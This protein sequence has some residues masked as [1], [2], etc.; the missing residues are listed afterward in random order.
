ML[1]VHWQSG[2]G[3]PRASLWQLLCVGLASGRVGKGQDTDGVPATLRKAPGPLSPPEL[4]LQP[5]ALSSRALVPQSYVYR[6][7]PCHSGPLFSQEG[8]SVQKQSGLVMAVSFGPFSLKWVI[9]FSGDLRWLT[10]ISTSPA[11]PRKKGHL[12]ASPHTPHLLVPGVQNEPST[13]T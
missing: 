13:C 8:P 10:V 5:W 7:P 9:Y 11:L 2:P 12:R 1:W 3:S 4:H 6:V